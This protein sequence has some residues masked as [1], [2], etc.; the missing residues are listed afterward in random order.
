[1][2]TRVYT[3]GGMV[4][5]ILDYLSSPNDRAAEALCGRLPF[6]RFWFGTG[7]QD[8]E[9]RAADLRLCL[10]CRSVQEERASGKLTR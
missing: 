8:E 7:T 5:H 3:E 6:P 10:T 4:A 1:M 2:T 9:E